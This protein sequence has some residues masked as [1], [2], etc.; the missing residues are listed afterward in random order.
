MAEGSGDRKMASTIA[1][2]A[3]L[4]PLLG[5]L[6]VLFPSCCLDGIFHVVVVVQV[7]R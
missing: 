1:A 5:G 6:D 4:K 3:L 2:Y 7:W